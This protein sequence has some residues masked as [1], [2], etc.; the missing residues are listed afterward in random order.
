MSTPS[1]S[2]IASRPHHSMGESDL[3][4]LVRSMKMDVPKF[5]GSD[6]S[7]WIFRIEEF[8]A[9]HN[10]PD[11]LRLSIVSFHLEGRASAWFRWMKANNL[12][13]SWASFLL[14]VKQRFGDSIYED[15]Q[16]ALS[17]LSQTSSVADFQT[18]FEDMMNKVSGVSESLLV[19]FFISGLRSDI[20]R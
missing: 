3:H 20:R 17:K 11:D 2:M 1:S 6:P 8:F 18:A 14:N 5:D 10:A 12:I 16:G 7:G 13:T 15:P 19:S 4:S 9:F